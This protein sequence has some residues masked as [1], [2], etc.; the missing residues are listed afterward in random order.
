MS[1]GTLVAGPRRGAHTPHE[2]EPVTAPRSHVDPP[3]GFTLLELTIVLALVLGGLALVAPASLADKYALSRA[4]RLAES[5]L[6]RARLHAVAS[7]SGATVTARGRALEMRDRGGALLTSVELAGGGLGAL[8]SV[9]IRPAAIRF[10][11]R[12]QGSAGSIYLYRGRRGV[13]VLS[14]FVGRVRKS[15]FRF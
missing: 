10:N 14:N 5:H 13:R 9:R 11:A 12:G 1:V 2:R 7:H 3:A 8:D 4:G 6:V 15:R